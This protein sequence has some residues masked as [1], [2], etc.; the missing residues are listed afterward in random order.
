MTASASLL[1]M[2]ESMSSSTCLILA[3]VLL[4][5]VVPESAMVWVTKTSIL[6]PGLG[7]ILTLNKMKSAFHKVLRQIR[8][9]A[10]PKS[11]F[12][13]TCPICWPSNVSQSLRK[14]TVVWPNDSSVFL[15]ELRPDLESLW[16][17][18][19]D[20]PIRFGDKA[21]FRPQKLTWVFVSGQ[22]TPWC[23]DDLAKTWCWGD[24]SWAYILLYSK[25]WLAH[26]M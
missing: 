18:A 2:Y 17:S 22:K 20:E 14:S 13:E 23:W 5:I 19:S 10:K 3:Q 25:T 8:L 1:R 9:V 16:K 7:S 24:L 11:S 4:Y 15:F 6:R 26:L 12:A 21:I